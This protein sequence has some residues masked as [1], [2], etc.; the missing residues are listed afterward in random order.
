MMIYHNSAS[1]RARALILRIQRRRHDDGLS[2]CRYVDMWSLFLRPSFTCN[3]LRFIS[4]IYEQRKCGNLFISCRLQNR[5]Q[6]YDTKRILRKHRRRLLYTHGPL[7]IT[8]FIRL[9]IVNFLPQH[10]SSHSLR[11]SVCPTVSHM[12]HAN[13]RAYWRNYTFAFF[14]RFAVLCT[15]VYNSMQQS[16]CVSAISLCAYASA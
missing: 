3:W 16:V 14:V 2:S 15:H 11:P 6:Q 9:L 7:T 8:L 5:S 4:P 12:D 13:I 1:A 10:A